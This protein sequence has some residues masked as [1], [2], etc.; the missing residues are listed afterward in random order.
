WYIA[1]N[2]LLSIYVTVKVID[3]IQTKHRKITLIIVTDHEEKI[4]QPLQSYF[5]RAITYLN[6]AGAY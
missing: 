1:L 5:L 4:K 2:F 3:A 6:V